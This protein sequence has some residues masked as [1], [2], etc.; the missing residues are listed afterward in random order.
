MSPAAFIDANVPV[1]ASGRPHPK[2]RPCARVLMMAAESP[3]S[4]VTSAEVLQEIVHLYTAS[5]RWASG[6]E[7]L[8][9]FADVMHGRIEPV[10]GEDILAAARLADLHTGV[11]ARD[12]VHAAVM[13]RLGIE[14]IVSA[15]RGF[16]RLPGLIRLEPE[17]VGEWATTLTP[18]GGA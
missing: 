7:V 13:Q 12:L 15:D 2:K 16:D 5:G 9:G 6:R 4:F 18:D 14:S 8:R 3:S 11:S 10:H 17:R 1:Y